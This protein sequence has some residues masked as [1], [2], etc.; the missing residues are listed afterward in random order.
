MNKRKL[1]ISAI[2]TFLILVVGMLV[3]H[4]LGADKEAV[5]KNFERKQEL[6]EVE[7][8][9]FLTENADNNIVIDGRLNSYK[10]VD[11]FSKVTG[12]LS[13]SGRAFKKGSYFEKGELLFDIDQR[14]A[15]YSLFALRSNLLNQVTQIMPDLKLDYPQ[16]F[17]NWKSYLDAFDVEAPVKPLPEI[18]SDQEKYFVASK[19]IYN[20]YYS[21]KSSEARLSDYQIY[22]PFSGVVTSANVFDGSMI[23]PGQQLGTLTSTGYYE[24]EAPLSESQLRYVKVG[25]QVELSSELSGKKWTGK[26]NRISSTI[27]P[28]TQSIPLFIGVSGSGLKE[29]MYLK[30]KLKASSLKAVAAVPKEIIVNQQFVLAVHDSTI[31]QTQLD[32]VSRDDQYVYV[33]GLDPNQ[34]VVRSTIAGLYEGQKVSPKRN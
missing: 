7:V 6:R 10:T 31:Q 30:G 21:I 19:N 25:Q 17:Q 16:A 22:A 15:R 20:T 32:I 33:S 24:L 1:I 4:K 29:G 26:V 28:T 27:D 13:S 8:A 14:E 34:W 11:L 12:Q 18:T 9:Q 2:L 3:Y 23:S 5:Q